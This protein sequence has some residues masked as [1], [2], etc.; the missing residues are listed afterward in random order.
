MLRHG[1]EQ[2]SRFQD[3]ERLHKLVN[4]RGGQKVCIFKSSIQLEVMRL[5]PCPGMSAES[6]VVKIVQLL[7]GYARVRI[8]T[9][10]KDCQLRQVSEITVFKRVD[11]IEGDTRIGR[12]QR[13]DGRRAA[14]TDARDQNRG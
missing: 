7:T 14:P 3:R 4:Q 11:P 6:G 5:L 13:H 8:L 1:P 10:Q 9:L 2:R 12:Q